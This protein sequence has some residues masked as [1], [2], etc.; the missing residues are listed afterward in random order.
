[1]ILLGVMLLFVGH[2]F[3]LVMNLLGAY[4][5]DARL[6]YVEFYGRFYEGD[7]E[8]FKPLGGERKYIYLVAEK[9]VIHKK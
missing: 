7:G 3:N 9:Q 4:I 1:M 5:H 6:Q 2:A 8:L